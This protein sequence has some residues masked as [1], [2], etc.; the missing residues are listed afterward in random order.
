MAQFDISRRGL[1]GSGAALGLAGM[2]PHLLLPSAAR[3]QE[4]KRG[5]HLVL[6]L[7]GGATSDS[8]DTATYSGSARSV[9]RRAR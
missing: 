9:R 2:V 8:L 5:G 6:G 1:L 3:A 7:N 4:P